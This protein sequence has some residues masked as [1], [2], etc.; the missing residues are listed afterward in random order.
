MRVVNKVW[1]YGYRYD[2]DLYIN[3][4]YVCIHMIYVPEFKVP[5]ERT[6]DTKLVGNVAIF[7]IDFFFSRI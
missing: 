3:K 5:P 4:S 6:E 1:S 2:D 7:S